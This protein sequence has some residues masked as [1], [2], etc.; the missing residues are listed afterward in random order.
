MRREAVGETIIV[1]QELIGEDAGEGSAAGAVAEAE[2]ANSANSAISRSTRKIASESTVSGRGSGARREG[3]GLDGV[4]LP[5]SPASDSSASESGEMRW[6]TMSARGAAGVSGDGVRAQTDSAA[7]SAT[8]LTKSSCTATAHGLIG[9]TTTL[10]ALRRVEEGRRKLR[11]DAGL[12]GGLT[13]EPSDGRTCFAS[14]DR[15]GVRLERSPRTARGR[16]DADRS[17]EDMRTGRVRRGGRAPGARR[18]EL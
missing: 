2:A 3:L 8:A 6:A 18:R 14:G 4:R 1:V 11:G 7:F 9:F 15:S 10:P 16:G 5:A 13:L 17:M 12:A